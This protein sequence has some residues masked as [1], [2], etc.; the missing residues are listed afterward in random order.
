MASKLRVSIQPGDQAPTETVEPPA[1]PGPPVERER[2]SPISP[3]KS[4][5]GGQ[6]PS[7]QQ[8]HSSRGGPRRPSITTATRARASR[9][10]G[11][12]AANPDSPRGADRKATS[13]TGKSALRQARKRQTTTRHLPEHIGKLEREV[14]AA[15]ALINSGNAGRNSELHDRLTT[16][17]QE[18]G[19]QYGAFLSGNAPGGRSC[20]PSSP[21]DAVDAEAS[22]QM[23]AG[24]LPPP[25]FL[26]PPADSTEACENFRIW[27]QKFVSHEVDLDKRLPTLRFSAERLRTEVDEA[28]T[29]VGGFETSHKLVRVSSLQR[30]GALRC[31]RNMLVARSRGL[32]QFA[33]AEEGGSVESSVGP[34]LD[35]L[36]TI[37][38]GVSGGS[39]ETRSAGNTAANS[40]TQQRFR[41]ALAG[42]L[43]R[44]DQEIHAMSKRVKTM[45]VNP[46]GNIDWQG[47]IL[48]DAALV[49]IRQQVTE[50]MS[51]KFLRTFL[52]RL[53]YCVV[54]HRA[55]IW[56]KSLEMAAV[57]EP[58]FGKEGFGA[59]RGGASSS[60]AGAGGTGTGSQAAKSAEQYHV[61]PLPLGISS[62]RHLEDAAAAL[63]AQFNCSASMK[64][65]KG[66][67]FY[68]LVACAFPV[69]F[70]AQQRRMKFKAYTGESTGDTDPDVS[71]LRPSAW[72]RQMPWR[73][74]IE[75]V[76][77]EQ[78][79]LLKA[80]H[81][82]ER[83]PQRIKHGEP[84]YA[85]QLVENVVAAA[86]SRG[87]GIA[88]EPD[89]DS[90]L[91]AERAFLEVLDMKRVA[92]RLN[93]FVEHKRAQD[94]EAAKARK[95]H[96]EAAA[97]G[98]SSGHQSRAAM[99]DGQAHKKDEELPQPV[100][101]A[102]FML[103]H[104]HCR[105]QR[106]RLLSF[107]NFCRFLQRRLVVGLSEGVPSND[108][109]SAA[110][111]QGKGKKQSREITSSESGMG[112]CERYWDMSPRTLTKLCSEYEPPQIALPDDE[113]GV[114]NPSGRESL[115]QSAADA[116][117]LDVL[118]ERG[119]PV[120]H[121]AALDDL[122][123]LERELLSIGSYYIHKF[124][125]G[126]VE[127]QQERPRVDRIGVLS[128]LY[129]A[130][131]WFCSEKRKL[132]E[133]YYEIYE[134]T[135]EPL[136]KW[137]LSQRI[138]DVMA[139]RPRL[140]LQDN[141]FSDGYAVAICL[142]QA[143]SKTLGTVVQHQLAA[144][145]SCVRQTYERLDS[146]RLPRSGAAVSDVERGKTAQRKG[147]KRTLKASKSRDKDDLRPLEEEEQS[148]EFSSGEDGGTTLAHEREGYE[149]SSYYSAPSAHIKLQPA[150]Q[151]VAIDEFCTTLSLAWKVEVVVEESLRDLAEHFHPTSPVMISFLERSCYAF[152]MEQWQEN[153][154][155]S[156]H[157]QRGTVPAAGVHEDPELLLEMLKELAQL[158]CQGN[159]RVVD[160]L[161]FDGEERAFVGILKQKGCGQ[162]ET[163]AFM[164]LAFQDIRRRAGNTVADMV[165][166][167]VVNLLEH[168]HIRRSLAE[169]VLE[170][171][172]LE[173][174][175]YY[176]G[177]L[178][179]AKVDTKRPAPIHEPAVPVKAGSASASQSHHNASGSMLLG[180]T[181][182]AGDGL[183]AHDR[184]PSMAAPSHMKAERPENAWIDHTAPALTG[185]MLSAEMATVNI[186]QTYEILLH[187]STLRLHEMRLLFQHEMAY[188]SLV[189]TS[190]QYNCLLLDSQVRQ[191]EASDV[192]LVGPSRDVV[193]SDPGPG[194]SRK[195]RMTAEL[196]GP[197]KDGLRRTSATRLGELQT[198]MDMSRYTMNIQNPLGLVA[199]ILQTIAKFYNQKCDELKFIKAA[200]ISRNAELRELWYKLLPC[201]SLCIT[202]LACD[203]KMRVQ[204]T[205]TAL[206][207][208]VLALT[209]PPRLSP[210]VCLADR[211]HAFIEKDGQVGSLFSIPSSLD[212][213][214]L[215]AVKI[216]GDLLPTMQNIYNMQAKTVVRDHK[217]PSISNRGSMFV[218]ASDSGSNK[219][220]GR[221]RMSAFIARTNSGTVSPFED[222]AAMP[223]LA[224]EYDGPAFVA[225]RLLNDLYTLVVLRYTICA[226][227]GVPRTLLRMQRA[228]RFNF[229]EVERQPNLA[230]TMSKT[231]PTY[232]MFETLRHDLSHFARRLD[233]LTEA[234]GGS[235][236][237][238]SGHVTP[239]GEQK[240]PATPSPHPSATKDPEKVL[241]IL[242]SEIR[243]AHRTLA[244][245]LRYA[246]REALKEGAED[247][248][249]ELRRWTLYL[250]GGTPSADLQ[251][252]PPSEALR[253][254]RAPVVASSPQLMPA[255]G[256]G[257][258][259]P[260]I[261][262]EEMWSE[263]E[264]E[265]TWGCRI[266]DETLACAGFYGLQTLD[267]QWPL[268]LTTLS[269]VSSAAA[270]GAAQAAFTAP[271]E[272]TVR[273]WDAL[274]NDRIRYLAL[275][276]PALSASHPL[277]HPLLRACI[278][279]YANCVNWKE[280]GEME[281]LLEEDGDMALLPLTSSSS[282]PKEPWGGLVH[283]SGVPPTLSR[284]TAAMSHLSD[285]RREQLSVLRAEFQ[286]QRRAYHRLCTV[287]SDEVHVADA[288]NEFFG[289]Y[290]LLDVLKERVISGQLLMA[291]PANASSFSRYEAHFEAHYPAASSQLVAAA[292]LPAVPKKAR[293]A[294]RA[295]SLAS[296]REEQENEAAK[297]AIQTRMQ[298]I[299]GLVVALDRLL[300]AVA[301]E[302]LGRELGSLATCRHAELAAKSAVLGNKTSRGEKARGSDAYAA[303]V[304]LV[305]RA[306]NQLRSCSTYVHMDDNAADSEKAYVFLE[307]DLNRCVEGLLHR[308]A[309]WG[310][311]IVR[312]RQELMDQIA[313][314]QTSRIHALEQEQRLQ[315]AYASSTGT[316]PES[317]SHR[318]KG[319]ASREA[320]LKREVARRGCQLVFEVDRIYLALNDLKVVSRE[321]EYRLSSE[322]WEKVRKAVEQIT[323]ELAAATGKFKAGHGERAQ[324]VA[325]QMREIRERIAGE[326]AVLAAK[327]YAAQERATLLPERNKELEASN[328]AYQADEGAADDKQKQQAAKVSEGL[329]QK[330]LEVASRD[331]ARLL[332]LKIE[333]LKERMVCLRHFHHL[334]CQ[335]MR[336][337]FGDQVRA[338]RMTLAANQELL[339]RVV[340]ASH[341]QEATA[342]DFAETAEQMAQAELR[343]EERVGEAESHLENRQR[344]QNWKKNKARQLAHIDQKVRDH[345]RVGTVDVEGNVKRIQ[346]KTEL[347][348]RLKLERQEEDI[349]VTK[350][351]QE[352]QRQTD[353]LKVDNK[354]AREDKEVARQHL[355]KW[356][357]EAETTS[358]TD[359]ER[360]D[361]WYGRVAAARERLEELQEEKKRLQDIHRALADDA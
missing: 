278:A 253:G 319:D 43:R 311:D 110:G 207:L 254:D 108:P 326:F 217:P 339:Q 78:A 61:A 188:R 331:D 10:A 38:G 15:E 340:E 60:G 141:Y 232:E 348:E 159:T 85:R 194:V 6:R 244:T 164:Q 14:A 116:D 296:V 332:R 115:R 127:G 166:H 209:I 111:T 130:E 39:T 251:Q 84:S 63:G 241:D 82:A 125:A 2:T 123:A 17:L 187:C 337:K 117:E 99:G 46:D 316:D 196:S 193:Q 139:V 213:L 216:E 334:K 211:K 36:G 26:E 346:E 87:E 73:A 347:L 144:Q 252:V 124:E 310:S 255:K 31:Q 302:R 70:E 320:L 118:D 161:S 226:I 277:L 101:E 92:H 286:D 45:K 76:L 133:L 29:K 54:S 184:V 44:I 112:M 13:P 259:R 177:V 50:D 137:D 285:R 19:E 28:L 49:L 225:L 122:A 94:E 228:A 119:R 328:S 145:R 128:D 34:S 358:M 279:S 100:L 248:A 136:E 258:G 275:F 357:K 199:P 153:L 272:L 235:H 333:E 204:A 303:K 274:Q 95:Q 179:S 69:V 295:E 148:D 114:D 309:S 89:V 5:G 80:S 9:L 222:K 96:E 113:C 12:A 273:R 287:G 238:A 360:A 156:E 172:Y 173:R 163:D 266:G 33:S 175:I 48:Q 57:C 23:G 186:T 40:H 341:H 264:K 195:L 146:Q 120:M 304:D 42:S 74:R 65:D 280:S 200:D 150:A 83:I 126:S 192:S 231:D 27:R 167:M 102:Y 210:F 297:L 198:F 343:I 214:L 104:L 107:L 62:R 41:T 90:V 325:K 336:Q 20:S 322:V 299:S 283:L 330:V 249:A 68:H 105:A 312:S 3:K 165:P 134:H 344:L 298:W 64:S 132:L 171:A 135:T 349:I 224:F 53:Q 162:V 58:E 176:Q 154:R 52:R 293:A 323:A 168:I 86:T 290:L 306:T 256:Q 208:R 291:P 247:D 16:L 18:Y 206:A 327:N 129:A 262:I 8:P 223:R 25:P 138:V 202:R 71:Y 191:K 143:R 236:A 276:H 257:G 67:T 183:S 356:R 284:L 230:T 245:L 354:R 35:G 294:N 205:R 263:T 157:A 32:L 56:R 98:A 329:R 335:A 178:F 158:L 212:L 220:A 181:S 314:Y 149:S 345:Q 215:R 103:R 233:N 81:A 289:T 77:V 190:C 227:D 47:P 342:K 352:F 267:G 4:E 131:V 180:S 109:R 355:E 351:V 189:A 93:D 218:G 91:S 197:Q 37:S 246:T 359:E 350:Q 301:C 317:G 315:A 79:T 185:G 142:M 7:I 269:T 182:A 75:P 201:S 140:D 361:L 265:G 281:E 308:M 250:E 338:L 151:P 219:A 155:W 106:R 240:A 292:A 72:A 59:A 1:L 237:A 324:L 203:L 221:T 169:M 318:R 305:L 313:A 261:A 282:L 160:R 21:R 97:A 51:T 234:P 353:A 24:V 229:V 174:T 260:L 22:F 268:G 55:R 307:E 288:D 170:V 121:S 147:S 300:A 243:A 66:K 30:L 321:L 270:L 271:T 239:S 88:W 242:Q 11:A 152:A